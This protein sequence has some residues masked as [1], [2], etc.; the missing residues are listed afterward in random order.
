MAIHKTLLLLLVL[1]PLSTV[2]SAEPELSVSVAKQQILL[3]SGQ[4]GLDYF[5]DQPVAVVGQRPLRCFMTVGNRTVAFQGKNWNSLR[6]GK[7][8]LAK[9]AKGSFDNGYAGVGGV[10]VM[11]RKMFVFY[12]AEDHEGLQRS[13]YTKQQTFKSSVALAVSDGGTSFRKRGQILTSKHPKKPDSLCGGIGDISIC[14]DKTNTYLLAH[15][16]DYSRFAGRGVQ[17]CVA[18]SEITDDG[19]PG[20]W[21]KYFKGRFSEPGL[22]GE[23]THILSWWGNMGD[24]KGD[25]YSP[26]VVYSKQLG[27]YLMVFNGV[28]Y[29]EV[30]KGKEARNPRVSG[31]YLTSSDDAIHWGKATQLFASHSIILNRHRLVVHPSIHILSENRKTVTAILLYG[32]SPR[33][34]VP[35]EGNIPHHLA[36]R[37]LTI[38]L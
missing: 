12:H 13:E 18:R 5:P 4:Y 10:Y 24:R 1:I 27:K 6:P 16:V 3:R 2:E 34:G 35:K 21:K 25:A 36:S 28:S 23:E 20:T 7:T 8:V 15:Y 30:R 37:T 22:G 19:M 38:S 33:W 14:V 32:H 31:I 29:A 17:T 26:H 9:G 11:G